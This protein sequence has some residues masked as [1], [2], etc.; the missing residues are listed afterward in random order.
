MRRFKST[1]EPLSVTPSRREPC[2]GDWRACSCRLCGCGALSFNPNDAAA[3]ITTGNPYV[4][5][6]IETIA[7]RAELIGDGNKTGDF[8]RAELLARPT[9]G[10][11]KL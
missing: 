2:N 4:Q 1:V 5:D 11:Q 9:C 8:C 7:K 6:A 10:R 3:R